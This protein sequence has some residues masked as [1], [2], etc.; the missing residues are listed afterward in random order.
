MPVPALQKGQPSLQCCGTPK[1]SSSSAELAKG[2]E[3]V[4]EMTSKSLE[5][6]TPLEKAKHAGTAYR[7]KS[8]SWWLLYLE[9][10]AVPRARAL[11][12]LR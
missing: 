3:E 8:E 9:G 2:G 6:K 5:K 12:R 11:G 1:S 7:C 4:L 10:K